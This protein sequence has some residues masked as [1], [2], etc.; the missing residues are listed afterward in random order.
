M[1]Q[2][3]AT[4]LDGDHSR[5]PGKVF[6]FGRFR[7]D[8]SKRTLEADGQPLSVS[9]RAFDILQL[10]VELRD[11]VVTKDEIMERVWPGTFVDENNLAVQISSLRRV[12]SAGEGA[13]QLIVTVPGRGYRF[14]GEIVEPEP[15]RDTSQAVETAEPPTAAPGVRPRRWLLPATLGIAVLAILAGVAFWSGLMPGIA[16]RVAQHVAPRLSIVV[17]PFR[18]LGDD[19]QESYLADAVSD[20]LTT[21]LSHIPGSVVIARA[22]ADVY[23]TRPASANQ[24]G[25]E[26]GV[27]YLLEGSLHRVGDNLTINAQLIDTGNGA[28]L[29]A[30]RFDAPRLKLA[31][32]QQTIVRRIAS[33]LNFTLMQIESKRSLQDRPDN[34]DA[35]DLFLR[36]RSM[37]DRDDSL[38]GLNNAQPLLEKAIQLQPDFVDAMSE[39]AWLLLNKAANFD[40]ATD[41]ADMASARKLITQ[42][43]E[44]AP[45]NSRGLAARAFLLK[46]DGRCREAVAS[47]QL[48]LSFNPNDVD[49]RTGL[50]LCT[51]NLGRPEE[52][53][54][55]FQ[56]TLLIDPQSPKNRVRYN[57]LGL[58]FLMLGRNEEAIDLF[59]RAM[60]GDPAP[61][62]PNESLSRREWNEIGLIAAYGLTGRSSE[63]RAR[64][65]TYARLWPNRTV[66]RLASY[67]TKAEVALPGLKAALSSLEAAGMPEFADENRD[68]GVAPS[69]I[70]KIAGDFET[71]PIT[72]PGARTVSTSA[73]AALLRGVN[74]PIVVDVGPG[75]A[76]IPGALWVN[77][78]F[79]SDEGRNHLKQEIEHS[80]GGGTDRSVVVM[81]SS[82]NDWNSYNASLT[83]IEFGYRNISWYRGGEEAWAAA[84]MKAEDRRD[85]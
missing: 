54:Q 28:H 35:L 34:P 53:A 25:R 77:D 65:A 16:G 33:A 84:G 1:P 43:V 68:D 26:L 7:L 3:Q 42:A 27:R 18:N 79:P 81:G 80:A 29:W 9:S 30:E 44:L 59:N 52:A 50:A 62:V 55:L 11:R 74:P 19:Q 58:I 83:L 24:I 75:A 85:P 73:L 6:E 40:D 51:V 8:A 31:E 63:A 20:D 70:P 32:T 72:V 45:Q 39:L 71:T 37:L 10:L 2:L 5:E 15:A 46:L 61:A 82:L 76:V 38:Q 49:A 67:L 12:L 69:P 57:Q 41:A 22:S 47:Y 13:A 78:T 23:K 60:A 21:D 4:R 64:Y 36:A 48:A 14:V 66:W 17:L 56:E